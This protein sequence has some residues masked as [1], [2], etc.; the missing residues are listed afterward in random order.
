MADAKNKAA[1]QLGSSGGRARAT[2]LSAEQRSEIGRLGAMAAV[3]K[4]NDRP[5][6]HAVIKMMLASI[7]NTGKPHTFYMVD[8]FARY[9]ESGSAF[10]RLWMLLPENCVGTYHVGAQFTDILSDVLAT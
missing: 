6:I 2:N 10:D 4:K 3:A 8:G 5:P 1:A 7:S 9:C